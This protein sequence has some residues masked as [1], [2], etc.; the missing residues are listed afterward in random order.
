[1]RY[2]RQV[3]IYFLVGAVVF[4]LYEGIKQLLDGAPFVLES[5]TIQRFLMA[6]GFGGL[7]GVLLGLTN[8][9][10]EMAQER[11][12]ESKD[13]LEHLLAVSAMDEEKRAEPAI[14]NL[15][16]RE[17]SDYFDA[18]WRRAIRHERPITLVL[19]AVDLMNDGS[20]D[21]NIGDYLEEFLNNWVKRPADVVIRYSDR[22]VLLLLPDTSVEGA[23]KF[24]EVLRQQMDSQPI[25]PLDLP[26]S[27][28]AQ[29]SV[30][31]ASG[32]PIQ[33]YRPEQLISAV[34]K[35]LEQSRREGFIVIDRPFKP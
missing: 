5:L 21:L 6:I 16:N 12:L 11:I 10:L 30:G 23:A 13:Q 1:M 15:E 3:I 32:I 8:L 33:G 27:E 20:G 31:L 24:V 28:F 14:G 34:E 35:A 29:T 9:R 22:S 17:F 19:C 4:C 25:P 7:A 2:L 18:E 26:L